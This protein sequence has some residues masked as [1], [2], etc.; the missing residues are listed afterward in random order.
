MS[1]S[2]TLDL[3]RHWPATVAE[4]VRTAGE[5]GGAGAVRRAL[6]AIRALP[7]EAQGPPFRLGVCRTFTI[8]PQLDAITL[9]L[10]TIPCR[11]V[12]TVGDLENIEQVLLDPS[13]ALAAGCDAVLVL[14]RLEDLHPRLVYEYELMSANER[15]QATSDLVARIDRLCQGYLTHG[16]T[17]LFLSTLPEWLASGAASRDVYTSHAPRLA[18]LRINQAL[19]EWSSRHPLIHVFDFSGWAAREGGNGFDLK[20]DLY[21]RQPIANRALWSFSVALAEGL[22]P[23]LRPPAKVL[24]IDLDNV[25]WGGI[26]G[27]DGIDGLKIGHDFPGSIYW[28]IQQHCLA[29]KQR[30]TLLVLLSKNNLPDV[31]AAF[32]SLLPMPLSLADF[33]ATRV[34]WS[35]K[36]D[37]LE[38]VAL[39]LKLGL[40]SFVFVDDQPFEREEVG[41]RLPAVHVLPA[42]KDPVQTLQALA[43]CRRFDTYRVSNEDRQRSADYDAQARRSELEAGSESGPGFLHTLGLRARIMRVTDALVPRA[44]QMLAKTNQF[45]ATTRRHSEAQVRRMIADPANHLLALSL[46]DRFGD[47]G[48]VA[49]AIALMDYDKRAMMVDSF[50]LSCRAIGRGAEDALW[51][52]LLFQAS[53]GPCPIVRSEYIRTAKNGQ[54]AALFTRFGMSR[55]G[56]SSDQ[57]AIFELVLPASFPSPPWIAVTDDTR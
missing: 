14:W 23:L 4:A 3:P 7:D 11:P 39:Q 5:A 20:M 53:A 10:A 51:S 32:A 25:L 16:S 13:S 34:N 55:L 1:R 56:H 27:E 24:A 15:E 22:A 38:E 21:A 40:D 12:I 42:S 26:L 28:R 47:Q 48:V 9:A 57:H 36:S 50:L 31:E 49:L 43:T 30:G 29:L 6:G 17:P 8:E 45:N 44:V 2:V 33:V 37:N 18:I 41:F 46:S 52:A 19:L 35:R 54:V